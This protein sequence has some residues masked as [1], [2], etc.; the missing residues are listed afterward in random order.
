VGDK[1]PIRETVLDTA[2]KLLEFQYPLIL[3]EMKDMGHQYFNS[4]TLDTLATWI[5][6]LD[7]I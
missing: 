7:R 5:D 2:K 3:R 4:V 6:L 1:D